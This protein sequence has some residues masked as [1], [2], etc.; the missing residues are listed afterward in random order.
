MLVVQYLRT[1]RLTVTLLFWQSQ[2]TII[3]CTRRRHR[4]SE[5]ANHAN[6]CTS[7]SMRKRLIHCLRKK[8]LAR[9]ADVP[10]RDLRQRWT[11]G[12]SICRSTSSIKCNIEPNFAIHA[13]AARASRYEAQIGKVAAHELCSC[14]LRAWRSNVCTRRLGG[15]GQDACDDRGH[16]R[17]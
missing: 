2:V 6:N 13:Q 12:D 7:R 1:C 5:L 15:C 16:I 17:C 11:S 8:W 9:A 10:Q 4:K 14:W 3:H